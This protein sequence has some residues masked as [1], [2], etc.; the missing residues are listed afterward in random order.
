[1]TSSRP[2]LIRALYEWIAD[3]AFTPHILVN[4]EFPGVSI[5]KEY[6]KNGEIILNISQSAVKNL[7]VGNDAVEFQARFSTIRHIY[8]PIGAVEAIYARENGQGMVFKDE[9]IDHHPDM[10]RK[11]STMQ[12]PDKLKK[13]PHLTLVKS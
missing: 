13:R 10:D 2:Y 11:Q 8:V 1:M 3:N 9:P 5:P 6:V 7:R 12:S 4:A